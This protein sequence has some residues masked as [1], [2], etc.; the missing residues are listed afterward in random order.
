[1]AVWF[2]QTN[3]GNINAAGMWNSNPAG[4][5]TVLTWPP[6]STDVLV[7]NNKTVLVNVNTI[8]AELR[9][10]TTGG[11]TVGGLFQL[12]ATGVSMTA[13]NAYNER[14]AANSYIV[15][16]AAAG[17]TYFV[18]NV[19]AGS[20]VSTFG[21]AQT[22]TGTLIVT[23]NLYG[24][25]G[26]TAYGGY[27]TSTGTI[28][29][30]GNLYGGDGQNA[31]GLHNLST[32]TVNHTGTA[33]G[34]SGTTARGA[35][36]N[37]GGTFAIVGNAIAGATNNGANN[38]GTGTLTISGYVEASTG[39]SGANNQAQGI[40]QVG[41]TRS[42]SNGLGAVTGAFRFASATAAKTM[43]YTPDGQ[44]SMTVL[45][46]AAIVPGAGDVRKGLVYGD[47]AYTGTLPLGR[48]R[49]SMA[50]RF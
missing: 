40:L 9:N 7:A 28:N 17:T 39:S 48:N 16:T 31:H 2:A 23:G 15:I 32:G 21:I 36:N 46:V 14:T 11:A 27:N 37:T 18:G 44:I 30:T 24:G 33:Y 20:L 26:T 6:G 38:Q 50:G 43:P 5:G 12:N 25:S 41:E 29:H 49:T 4:G 35:S 13:T 1:M 34:G 8:V 3:N 22:G 42:A 45:D 10:G 19:Y 47:G